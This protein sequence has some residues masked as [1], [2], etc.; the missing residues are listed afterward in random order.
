MRPFCSDQ[1]YFRVGGG[2]SG[3]GFGR[4]VLRLLSIASFG[5]V[6]SSGSFLKPPGRET[7]SQSRSRSAFG[8]GPGGLALPFL[9]GPFD[10]VELGMFPPN[11][12]LH[13]GDTGPIRR[14]DARVANH[15]LTSVSADA[16]R[17]RG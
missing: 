3:S 8:S 11:E 9:G 16:H 10:A 1:G 17:L 4:N 7:V 14:N 15:Y 13:Q 5:L 2:V 6:G 12:W